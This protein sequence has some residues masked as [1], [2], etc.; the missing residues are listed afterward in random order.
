LVGWEGIVCGRPLIELIRRKPEFVADLLREVLHVEVPTFTEAR[1]A[2]AN[3]TELVP[4]EYHADAVV[5]L[6]NGRPVFGCI[7]E[8]QLNEDARKRFSWPVYAIS[9]RARFECPFVLVVATPHSATARWAAKPIDLGAGQLWAPLVVGPDG[10][11]VI[12]DAEQAQRDPEL[13]VLSLMAHGKGDTETAVAIA[14]AATA[15]LGQ[16]S[17]EQRVL[18]LALIESAL[19]DAARKAFEMHPQ[20]EKLMS[21]WQR[22]S[23]EKGTAEGLLRGKAEAVLEVLEGRG[24]PIAESHRERILSCSDLDLIKTWLRSAVTVASA[25]QLFS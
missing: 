21:S 14:L 4:T 11:P 16:L 17:N 1:L 5:L 22:G 10:I 18:Y 23:F 24:L 20:T 25:D 12:I 13:A 6:I 2:E 7:F 19:G 3:L 15:S 8:A 9:A